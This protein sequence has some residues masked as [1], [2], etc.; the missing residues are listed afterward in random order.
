MHNRI[1]GQDAVAVRITDQF[2]Q[3]CYKTLIA[4][5]NGPN[6]TLRIDGDV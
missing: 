3:G 5:G 4:F 2:V 1:D 6:E